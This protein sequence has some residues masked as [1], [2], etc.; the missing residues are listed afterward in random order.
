MSLLLLLLREIRSLRSLGLDL[1]SSSV[2]PF[3]QGPEEATGVLD[4][5]EKLQYLQWH[6]GHLCL[7]FSSPV[8][9]SQQYL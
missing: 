5:E 1:C 6:L 2:L 8:P 3:G 9:R 7:F 4:W